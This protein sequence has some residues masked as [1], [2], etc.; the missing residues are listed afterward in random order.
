MSSGAEQPC[1]VIVLAGLRVFL[2]T[3]DIGEGAEVS[4][5][6]AHIGKLINNYKFLWQG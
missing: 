1:G 4:L 2:L 3:D 5:S 6:A